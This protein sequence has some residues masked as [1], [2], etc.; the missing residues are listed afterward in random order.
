MLVH[1]DAEAAQANVQRLKRIVETGTSFHTRR[2]WK[3]IVSDV[4]I[5]AERN[6]LIARFQSSN[7]RLTFDAWQ[8]LDSFFLQQPADQ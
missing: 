4:S 3:D 7:P 1:A 6:L 5:R 8:N 2:P